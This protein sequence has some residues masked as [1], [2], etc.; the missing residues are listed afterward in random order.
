MK[1]RFFENVYYA[2]LFM[3]LHITFYS[4]S[5]FAANINETTNNNLFADVDKFFSW[6]EENR[7]YFSDCT[8]KEEGESY[9]LC[10]NTTISKKL[11][12]ELF[13]M[14]V[15]QLVGFIKN[16][17]INL[18]IFCT[19][20][21]NAILN[22]YCIPL[23]TSQ[24]SDDKD[25]KTFKDISTLHGQY[26]PSTNT[27][28]LR[29]SASLGSLIHEYIHYLQYKNTNQV[30]SKRYKFER[31]ELQKKLV[32]E[33]DQA[34]L[35][36]SELEK[37]AKQKQL[38]KGKQDNSVYQPYIQQVTKASSYLVKF[39]LWQDLIDEKNIFLL[40]INFGKTIGAT[41]ED[42]ALAQ[43]N[44]GFI[45]NRKDIQL[46]TSVCNA[47]ERSAST[48]SFYNM[49]TNIIKEIRPQVN[50]TPI[51]DF[52]N[53]LP[54]IDASTPLQDVSTTLKDYIFNKLKMVPDTDYTSINNLD[55]ILPDSS[56]TQKRAH[57][58]G[59]TILYL[60]AGEKLGIPIHLV[61][62]PGHVFPRICNKTE[63]INVETLKQ[64][65]VLSDAEYATTYQLSKQAISEGFYLKSLSNTNELAASIYL[66]L[67]YIT[68]IH[69][70]LDL[71]ELFYK[72]AIDSSRGFADTYSNLAALYS[73]QKKQIQTKIY[74]EIALK[75]NPYHYTSMVNM[76]AY[77][78][79]IK[80]FAKSEQYYNN[81][82]SINSNCIDALSRRANL[83]LAQNKIAA[84]KS[85]FE[86]VLSIDPKYCDITKEVIN[87]ET[88]KQLASDKQLQ[89]NR[90]EKEKSCKYLS[91]H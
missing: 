23:N 55:N 63:C 62:V 70:Q 27:I 25:S 11:L 32:D 39:S 42:I 10:D 40:Y 2:I 49:V 1:N 41:G 69:N 91:I 57:C 12:T 50:L 21:S 22:K 75:I 74:L 34:I 6:A 18:K 87:L 54:K 79:N 72:K 78:F 77:Y 88:D 71:S 16:E 29:D 56:L 26:K 76:G 36:V 86:K 46:P 31:I 90:L 81:A 13:H 83:Y 15:D 5:T 85:D 8:P 17:K 48:T 47:D 82:L 20:N 64:G 59:L 67:G 80:D 45:C 24:N 38:P 30:F 51:D 4:T 33:M 14:N 66:G 7:K 68:N 9:I 58:L 84:A 65:T 28:F 61:R 37:Q 19:P 44:M 73:K 53:N 60:L 3:L 89:L 52:L 43:K 35:Q